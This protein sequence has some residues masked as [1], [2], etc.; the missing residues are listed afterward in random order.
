MTKTTTPRQIISLNGDWDLAF[1]PKDEGKTEN[2]FQRFPKPVKVPVPG[3]W[4]TVRPNY[5]G[6]GWYRTAFTVQDEWKGQTL[7]LRFGAVQ[8]FCECWLNGRSLGSHEGGFAPFEFDISRRAHAGANELVVRVINPPMDY[9]IE[10]FRCGAP[11]NQGEIPVG[12]AGWYYN[13]GGIWQ[14]VELIVT[15]PTW[16]EDVYVQPYPSRKK[17]V[18]NVTLH[19][20]ELKGRCE[21]ECVVTPAPARRQTATSKTVSLKSTSHTFSI[22]VGFD[23]VNLWSPDDPFLYTATVTLRKNGRVVDQLCVRFGMREFTIRGGQFILNGEPVV[24]KGFLQQGMYP[25]T[26]IF[27]ETREMAHR[28]LTLLKDNGFNFL[29]AHLRPPNPYYLDMADELGILVEAEPPI[30]WIG[31][32][33][34]TERRCRREIEGMILRDRNHASVIFWCLMNE[35]YHFRGYTMSQ[36]KK[37]T[38]RLAARARALDPTRLLMDTSGGGGSGVTAGTAVL[39]PNSDRSAEMIDAHAYC[40]LPPRD[41]DLQNYRTAGQRGMAL[42]VSEYGA[43]ETP[44]R[45][46]EVLAAYSAKERRLGLEDY[47]LHK[48]FYDSLKLRFRQAGLRSVF[49]SV[50]ALIDEVNR[51][52]AEET[53]LITKAMRVNPNM[54]GLTF[55]QLADASGELFGATDVWRNPKP[56]FAELT[57]AVETPLIV[58]DILP[59]VQ[60]IG[61]RVSLRVDLVNE[62]MRDAKYRFRVEVV[63]AGGK[64]R[65]KFSGDVQARQA[66]QSILQEK[67][68]LDLEPGAYTLRAVLMR[69]RNVASRQSMPFTVIAETAVGTRQVAVYDR[70]GALT[71]HLRKIGI[72]PATFSNNYRGKDIPVLVDLRAGLPSRQLVV[73]FYGQLKKIVQLGGCAVLFE[74]EAML[75][76]EHLFPQLIRMQGVMRTI[77]Y[78]KK[79]AMFESLPSNGVVGYEYADLCP[80]NYDKAEDVVAAGGKVLMGAVSMHMWTRPAK[81]FWGAGLYTVPIGSGTV[82]VC[83]MRVLDNLDSSPVARRLLTNI[84]DHAA[85]IIV[86]GGNEKLLSRCID[87]LSP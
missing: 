49:G 66:I 80:E 74:P 1:D 39:L 41:E 27:P 54:G 62:N 75:L 45:Y 81:Y 82:V 78:V 24:L 13:F 3:V 55:C 9:E 17:A 83:N 14:D 67:L 68:K 63:Q 26:I 64:V 73:E 11:L 43:P 25:R 60:S 29:R 34:H 44:P 2:W 77:G 87:P 21:V 57:S 50:S 4:E 32:T 86:P 38:A 31:N 28:E 35:A 22:P 84:I 48:D 69:G 8:Y 5:D 72:R 16:I 70:A 47:Q 53:G 15:E 59:R 71:D 56:L 12:K 18:V 19:S 85:S 7:R 10:G 37:L 51:V 42:F 23:T 36:I 20:K 52:R 61:Q 6:V 58:P 79:H 40:P 65:K 46:D 76:Y 33:P 30:G